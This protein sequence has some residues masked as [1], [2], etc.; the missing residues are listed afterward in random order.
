MFSDHKTH[1]TLPALDL[2][3]ARKWYAEKLGLVPASDNPAGLFYVLGGTRFILYP[4]PNETRGGHTQM[5]VATDDIQG[6]VAELKSRGVVFEEYD[7]PGL[8]TE[9]GIAATGDARAAWFKDSEGN[10]IGV[11]QLPPGADPEA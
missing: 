3:R 4:T 9:G 2:G 10:M 8:K 6:T 1:T 7:F 11:V 5:G